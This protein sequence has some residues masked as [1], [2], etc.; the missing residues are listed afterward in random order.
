[1]NFNTRISLIVLLFVSLSISAQNWTTHRNTDLAFRAE[2]LGE[3]KSSVQKVPTDIGDIDMH[4]TSD[5]TAEGIYMSIIRSDYP[6]GTMTNTK[7]ALDGAVNG[8]TTNVKGT[9]VF[10]KEDR[11]NGFP[12]RKIKIKAQGMFLYMNVYLVDDSM[13]VAQVVC[14]DDKDNDPLIDKFLNSFDI[15]RVKKD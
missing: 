2:F 11:F 12:G 3:P 7:T 14:V 10:D 6:E 4:M 8:A 1:M 15:I 13:Y 5:D 9:L